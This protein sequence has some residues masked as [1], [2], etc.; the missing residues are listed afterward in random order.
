MDVKAPPHVVYAH[1]KFN[2]AAGFHV[3]SLDYL[4]KFTASLRRDL[5]S[6]PQEN[7]VNPTAKQK[8]DELTHLLARCCY[9][10]GE[11]Q[12]AVKQEWNSVSISHHAV[13][14]ARTQLHIRE[15][16]KRFYARM[17]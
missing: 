11:W 16:S 15:T 10:Q 3:E 4:Q 13:H 8:I 14:F 9:K 17:S 2:W 1:L 7:L 6:E 5:D 12:M